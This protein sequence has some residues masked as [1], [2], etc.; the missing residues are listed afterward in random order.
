MKGEAIDALTNKVMVLSPTIIKKGEKSM[1]YMEGRA[2]LAH[3][4]KGSVMRNIISAN[5]FLHPG[6]TQL[7]ITRIIIA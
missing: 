7:I 5:G 2:R 4:S 6:L 1:P 3:L